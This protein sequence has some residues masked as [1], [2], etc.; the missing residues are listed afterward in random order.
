MGPLASKK[1]KLLCWALNSPSQPGLP[2]SFTAHPLCSS[3][4]VLRC[5]MLFLTLV[6]LLRLEP[7]SL[8]NS[9]TPWP[10]PLHQAHWRMYL[11]LLYHL[12]CSPALLAEMACLWP[13]LHSRHWAVSSTKVQIICWSQVY[14]LA[15]FQ[16]LLCRIGKVL[17]SS[18]IS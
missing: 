15:W 3:Y 7:S 10:Q 11:V 1:S 13:C 8:Q 18:L 9:K 6:F 5:A 4:K 2:L 12:L 14:I 16:C 17:Y